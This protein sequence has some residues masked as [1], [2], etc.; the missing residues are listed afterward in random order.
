VAFA[1]ENGCGT[2][3]WYSNGIASKFSSLVMAKPP[4]NAVAC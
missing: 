4:A 3:P 1:F 2:S